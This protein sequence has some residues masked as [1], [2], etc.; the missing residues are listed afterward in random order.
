MI[1]TEEKQILHPLLTTF[2]ALQSKVRT[3][4]RQLWKMDERQLT[5]ED[6]RLKV[7]LVNGSWMIRWPAF[8]MTIFL[9]VLFLTISIDKTL[10]T[11]CILTTH[12]ISIKIVHGRL[13]TMSWMETGINRMK[14]HFG[15]TECSNTNPTLRCFSSLA[16]QT[17]P[18]QLLELS[19]GLGNSDGT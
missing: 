13:A 3:T 8:K 17:V 5:R 16:T 11:F 18:F 14:D 12:F 4:E 1:F 6:T 15:F 7:T 2:G 19:D 9:E 10:R